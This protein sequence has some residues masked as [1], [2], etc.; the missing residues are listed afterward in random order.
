LVAAWEL[1]KKGLDVT[2]VEKNKELGGALSSVKINGTYLEKYYHHTFPREKLLQDLVKELEME[3]KME[4][5]VGTVAFYYDNKVYR[6]TAPIDLLSYKPLNILEKALLG[7]FM[8]QI[9]RIKDPSKY[10]DITAREWILKNTSAGVY[11]KMFEPLIKSKFGSD[12]D[13]IS[14]AWFIERMKLRNQRGTKGEILGYMRGGFFQII[15]ELEKRIKERGGKILKN[16]EIKHVNVV[17]GKVD[18]VQLSDGTILKT[19]AVISTISPQVTN[20]IFPDYQAPNLRLQGAIVVILG[21]DKK[22]TQYYWTNVIKEGI[23]IGAYLEHTNFIDSGFYG[24]DEVV[25]LAS[26]PDYSANLW[27]MGEKEIFENYFGD[28]QK[29]FPEITK[30]NVRW[31]VASK[32]KDV[33]LVYETGILSRIPKCETNIKNLFI[34]GLAN[35]YP[36]RSIDTSIK[37]G[38]ICA[39]LA[40]GVTSV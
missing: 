25:Y 37:F 2:I 27:Q 16:T 20:R 36:E 40:A 28:L 1:V 34:G 29:L 19:H 7:K 8:L 11:K 4:W 22:L 35:S 24:G 9:L 3:N 21:M 15:E 18:G 39:E 17:D 38:K 33:G 31:W 12:T 5:K 26:Y 14:A 30:E 6:M 32:A 23:R 10:D 13:R